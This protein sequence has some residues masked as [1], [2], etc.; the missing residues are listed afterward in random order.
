MNDMNGSENLNER[1]LLT[2][3]LHTEKELT[4]NYAGG[5]TEASCPELRRIL[6][7]NMTEC[8]E[9]QFSVFEEMRRRNMYNPKDAQSQEVQTAKQAMQNLRDETW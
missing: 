5:C 3:L 7:R 4:K 8:S 1:E 9:D 2:D 6:I